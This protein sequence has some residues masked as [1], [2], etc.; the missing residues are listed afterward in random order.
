VRLGIGGIDKGLPFY[1]RA[2]G[3]TRGSTMV[4]P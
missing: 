2:G 4:S 1:G 3:V